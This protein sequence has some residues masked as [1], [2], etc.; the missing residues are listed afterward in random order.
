MPDPHRAEADVDVRK[1]HPEQTRPGPLLVSCVQAAHAI[2]ELV[3]HRVFRDAVER[4]SDQVAERVAAEYI[5]AEKHNVHHQDEASDADAEA[6]GET[7]GH[8]CVVDQK[9]PHQVGEPQKVAMEI[10]QD[11][12]KASFAE[13]GLARLADGARRRIGPERFVVR[14][15]V[16]VTGE[17]EEAGYPKNEKRRRKRQ[18]ARIPMRLGAEERVRANRRRARENRKGRCRGRRCSGCSATPPTW[19]K[20]EMRLIPEKPPR[21][22]ATMDPAGTS[23]EPAAFP[24]DI[25]SCHVSLHG[26]GVRPLVVSRC[27]QGSI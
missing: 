2:V 21:A 23:A 20:P 3:P 10:L 27:S 13:I 8:D 22:K 17:P 15:A 1:S 4:A 25:G 11:Q 14:A 26:R 7:E 16:V 6:V 24:D 12:R 19:S 18:K 9:G 5:S